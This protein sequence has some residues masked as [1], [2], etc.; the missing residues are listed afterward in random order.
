L[1]Q[2]AFTSLSFKGLQR[3]DPELLRQH[4]AFLTN[5][6]RPRSAS[7]PENLDRA[8]HYIATRF[9]VANGTTSMQTFEARG[10]QYSNVIA[11]WGPS[12]PSLPVLV[13]GAHYDSFGETGDLPA[14]TTTPAAPP[15]SWNW[16]DSL[17]S[18][19]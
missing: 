4:V 19:A 9:R 5:D 12:D 1:R 7:H 2:P 10:R 16:R 14:P 17:A 15:D 13:I 11:R 6:V 8:A 3:A 18:I